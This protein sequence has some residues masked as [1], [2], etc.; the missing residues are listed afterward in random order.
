MQVNH[1]QSQ[2]QMQPEF[3]R[4]P[5]QQPSIQQAPPTAV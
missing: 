2:K 1:A 4:E 3:E 5:T